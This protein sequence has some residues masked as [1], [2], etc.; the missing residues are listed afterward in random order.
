MAPLTRS[1]SNLS[2]LDCKRKRSVLSSNTP[3]L[4]TPSP[5]VKLQDTH[6]IRVMEQ[7]LKELHEKPTQTVQMEEKTREDQAHDGLTDFREQIEQAILARMKTTLEE[8]K[9]EQQSIRVDDTE[10]DTSHSANRAEKLNAQNNL[11]QLK[12]SVAKEEKELQEEVDKVLSTNTFLEAM[13][14]AKVETHAELLKENKSLEEARPEDK[15]DE[16]KRSDDTEV[17][18]SHSTNRAKKLSADTVIGSLLEVKA[19]TPAEL[20]EL[21]IETEQRA[22]YEL[23]TP[24]L[25]ISPPPNLLDLPWDSPEY[26]LQYP[27]SPPEFESVSGSSKSSAEHGDQ[28]RGPSPQIDCVWSARS[29]EDEIFGSSEEESDEQD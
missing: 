4:S 27:D 7:R 1:R 6:R 29:L 5:K 9:D 17:D 22:S 23:I 13:L 26:D 14:E 28:S 25:I 2:R 21:I 19:I 15:V 11:T 20:A 12:E 10:V 3:S 8:W 24:P 18:T 16:Q